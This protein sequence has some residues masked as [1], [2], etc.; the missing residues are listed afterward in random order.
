MALIARSLLNSTLDAPAEISLNS[1][2]SANRAAAC[3]DTADGS[4][5]LNVDP[6]EFSPS[7]LLNLTA[8]WLHQL[9][10]CYPIALI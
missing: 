10:K 3:D 4:G 7:V 2:S 8:I 5:G 9:R 1:H 6:G